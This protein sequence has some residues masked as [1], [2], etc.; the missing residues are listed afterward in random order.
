MTYCDH[1]REDSWEEFDAR[2]IYLCRVCDNCR[3]EKLAGFRP[4]VLSDSNYEHDEPI[5]EEHFDY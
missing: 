3:A 5:S 4:E 1:S 2:G